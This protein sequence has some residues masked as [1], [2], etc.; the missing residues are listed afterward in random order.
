MSIAFLLLTNK[1]H[2][3]VNNISKFLKKGNI[4]VHPKYQNEITSY[5][6]EH[7]ITNLVKTS[8]GNLSI[9]NAEYNLLKES[10]K[11]IKNKWFIL[12]SES[13]YPIISY[14]KLLKHLN[15]MDKS[16]FHLT[17]YFPI[18]NINFFKSNQF[19]I[20]KRDDVEVIL[21]NYKKYYG[22]H[23]KYNNQIL[24]YGAPDET[25]F[26]TL[27]MNEIKDYDFNNEKSTFT[28]WIYLTSNKHPFIFNKL[29]LLDKKIIK[30]NKSFFIRKVSPYFTIKTY[31]NKDNLIIY[32]FD[33][34]NNNNIKE[35]ESKLDSDYIIFYSDYIFDFIPNNIIK[36]AIYLINIYYKIS[37]I[38]I[39]LFKILYQDLLS[40]WKN[41]KY[42]KYV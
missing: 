39:Q 6:K 29:T 35:I 11:N 31:K 17:S 23:L 42:I 26:I 27:L 24:K 18:E 34:L 40:Q 41:I 38:S 21:K 9:V 19:W 25:F 4:Y 28:R 16:Y 7:I 20:L 32:Y 15:K 30:E 3:H 22:L 37:D 13:C 12:L 2:I 36:N 8:W 33:K 1:E 5:L 14:N 10:Y